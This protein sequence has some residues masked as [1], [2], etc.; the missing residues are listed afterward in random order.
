MPITLP[1]TSQPIVAIE[2]KLLVLYGP[3]KCGKTTIISQLPNCLLVDCEDGSDYVPGLKIKITT[4]AELKELAATIAKEPT[5]PYRY[6]A[7]D[8]IDA[9]ESL[10]E[11]L[12]TQMYKMTPIGKSFTGRSVLLL[13]HGAGYL[14]L[15]IAFNNILD[16]IRAMAPRIILIGHIRDKYLTE[17]EGSGVSS[18]DLDL[19]GK[20]RSIVCSKADA[21]GYVARNKQGVLTITFKTTEEITCGSRSSHLRGQ[22]F[23]FINPEEAWKKIYVEQ[24]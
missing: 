10:C 3:P 6:V 4:I 11:T 14:W 9:I 7:I 1:K 5:P 8:T 21:I 17:K 2:P 15:R 13:D 12:A 24:Q 18:K 22:V 23:E 16:I 20:I 19:T